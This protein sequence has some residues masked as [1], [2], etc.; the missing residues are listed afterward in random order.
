LI[1]DKP[2]HIYM[3]LPTLQAQP[4]PVLEFV[5]DP[6]VPFPGVTL[7]HGRWGS[8]K[9][10]VMITEAIC[11]ASGQ[12]FLGYP[13]NPGPVLVIE[14]DMKHP[15]FL[16][17]FWNPLHAIA[18]N[19]PIGYIH[20]RR[21]NVLDPM[22]KNSFLGQDFRRA[23]E[24][25]NPRLVLVDALRST[26]NRDERESSSSCDVYDAW[27]DLFPDAAIQFLAHDRKMV[28]GKGGGTPS[29][30]SFSGHQ[31]WL[32]DAQSALHIQPTS[33]KG[34]PIKTF[35]IEHNKNQVGEIEARLDVKMSEKGDW[36]DLTS[37]VVK[38][39]LD[40]IMKNYQPGRSRGDGAKEIARRLNCSIRT[41][42]TK[43]RGWE[44]ANGVASEEDED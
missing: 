38:D 33:A 34:V 19:L 35:K 18:P 44:Q 10:A 15:H 30:E 37:D 32:N 7:L 1:E 27:T 6:L 13:V 42:Q 21:F 24:E 31:G 40:D 20:T 29:E 8:G 12:P 36:M 4:K 16:I 41:A 11:V 43:R 39:T 17:R 3:D 28:V 23:R 2:R 26:H 22:F 9:S 14:A 5:I 25:L